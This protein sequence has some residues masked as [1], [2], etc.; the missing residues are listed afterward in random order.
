[1]AAHSRQPM[2]EIT[3]QYHFAEILINKKIDHIS[4]DPL[5]KILEGRAQVAK[6]IRALL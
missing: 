5:V 1:M 4:T 2:Y 3:K 6:A